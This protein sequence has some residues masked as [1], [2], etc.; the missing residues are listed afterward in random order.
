VGKPLDVLAAVKKNFYGKKDG[1]AQRV[2]FGFPRQ[3]HLLHFGKRV[4]NCTIMLAQT[5]SSDRSHDPSKKQN[6]WAKP[7]S[8][9]ENLQG[10]VDKLSHTLSAVRYIYWS[11]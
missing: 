3:G 9:L 8:V 11:S 2:Q 5:T 7:H 1:P 6:A 4:S 10:S